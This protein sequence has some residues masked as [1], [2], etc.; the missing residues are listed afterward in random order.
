M[1]TKKTTIQFQWGWKEQM[2]SIILL[3]ENADEKGKAY[4]RKELLELGEKLDTYN[5]L[6]DEQSKAYNENNKVEKK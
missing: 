1:K 4:A 3:L 2:H 5:A 6:Q